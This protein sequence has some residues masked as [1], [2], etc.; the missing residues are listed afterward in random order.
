[1][2]SFNVLHMI[3]GTAEAADLRYC[4]SE[5][6]IHAKAAPHDHACRWI[7]HARSKAVRQSGSS[8]M[9]LLFSF[10]YIPNQCQNSEKLFG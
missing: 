10:W 2:S 6:A 8:T 7:R 9:S 4:A 1:M 5:P 3:I